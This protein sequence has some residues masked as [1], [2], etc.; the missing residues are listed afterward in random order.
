MNCVGIVHYSAYAP[1]LEFSLEN[2]SLEV[3][4]VDSDWPP[5]EH[6]H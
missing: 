1:V 4:D 6:N 3:V 5:V 2:N